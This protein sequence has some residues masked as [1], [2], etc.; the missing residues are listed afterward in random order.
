MGTLGRVHHGLPK[1]PRGRS[2]LP[3]RAVHIAQRER[4]LRAVIAAVAAKGYAAV[5]VAD[6]VDGARVSRQAFYEHFAGKEECFLVATDEGCE[7]M[8]RQVVEATRALPPRAPAPERL[9][10]AVR[11]YLEFIAAEPEFARTFLL[12]ALAAGP[13]AV[14]RFVAA[15]ERFAEL[16]RRWHA[17]ARREHPS[18]PAVSAEAYLAMV[19]AF[20]ELV[21]ACV[22]E[23]RLGDLMKLENV[24]IELHLSVFAGQSSSSR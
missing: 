20:H 18:W 11:A 1:L 7:L 22:R 17:R 21:A 4:L 24:V 14:E 23:G 3:P 13:A 16:T 5:T 8:F 6:V 19:G 12:E 10:A 2:S 9:R 15:H